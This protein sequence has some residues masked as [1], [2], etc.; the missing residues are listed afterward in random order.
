MIY[1]VIASPIFTNFSNYKT[2]ADAK[3]TL[4]PALIDSTSEIPE[5]A[6]IYLVSTFGGV[7]G[8]G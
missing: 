1:C 5:N 8:E 2:S 7:L 3:E 6:T 4:V